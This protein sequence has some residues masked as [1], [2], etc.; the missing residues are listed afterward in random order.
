MKQI[1][2]STSRP[3]RSQH[4]S[5]MPIWLA[6]SPSIRL[7][8]GPILVPFRLERRWCLG[9]RGATGLRVPHCWQSLTPAQSHHQPVFFVLMPG[10]SLQENCNCT[11]MHRRLALSH[12]LRCCA[13][14]FLLHNN[15]IVIVLLFWSS[16][17]PSSWAELDLMLKTSWTLTQIIVHQFPSIFI[18]TW[19]EAGRVAILDVP[20]NWNELTYPD[21]LRSI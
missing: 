10:I 21:H 20:L 5:N 17:S 8:L 18:R 15:Y 14:T 3:Y 12:T 4:D 9:S 16:L 1:C 11:E 7:L 19:H 6:L 13:C 2:P